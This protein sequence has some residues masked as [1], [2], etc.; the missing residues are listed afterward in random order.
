VIARIDQIWVKAASLK[1]LVGFWL[2]RF[3]ALMPLM[4][5]ALACWYP[6]FGAFGVLFGS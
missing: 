1:P 5:N 6:Y 4:I 2:L 3:V